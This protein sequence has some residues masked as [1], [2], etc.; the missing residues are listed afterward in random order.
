[1]RFTVNQTV[2]IENGVPT[3]SL[4]LSLPG[5]NGIAIQAVYS[6]GTIAVAGFVQIR[7]INANTATGARSYAQVQSAIRTGFFDAVSGAQG[8]GWNSIGGNPLYLG[9]L[10]GVRKGTQVARV[11][12]GTSQLP[13]SSGGFTATNIYSTKVSPYTNFA[14]ATTY[15]NKYFPFRFR[16]S[17]RDGQWTYGWIEASLTAQ[18]DPSNVSVKII[19]Y[20]WEPDGHQLMMGELPSDA[21]P[22]PASA[23][24]MALGAMVLGARGVRRWKQSRQAEQTPTL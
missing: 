7:S 23:G 14:F 16:D 22:E 12:V 18:S 19:S 15:A 4:A 24:L 17:T 13:N 20:A 3:S 5:V 1:M 21:I 6:A 2:G 9:S 10:G 11:L 8:L